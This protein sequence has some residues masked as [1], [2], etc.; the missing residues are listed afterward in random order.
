MGSHQWSR[1]RE[2]EGKVDAIYTGGLTIAMY[3]PEEPC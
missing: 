2:Q 3:R 1:Q